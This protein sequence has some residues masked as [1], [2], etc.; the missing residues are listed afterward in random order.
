[1]QRRDEGDEMEFLKRQS[2]RGNHVNDNKG[3]KDQMGR[4]SRADRRLGKSVTRIV[5]RRAPKQA[6]V[7]HFHSTTTIDSNNNQLSR[8]SREAMRPISPT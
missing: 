5:N 7:L 2:A 8:D 4:K 3:K 1:M 6:P